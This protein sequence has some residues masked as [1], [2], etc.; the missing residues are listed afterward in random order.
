MK[1]MCTAESLAIDAINDTE[2]K[3]TY[4]R[5]RVKILF[6]LLCNDQI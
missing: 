2:S 3:K 6:E 5:L 4:A 1:R